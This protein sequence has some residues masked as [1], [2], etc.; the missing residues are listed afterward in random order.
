MT[1]LK[2]SKVVYKTQRPSPRLKCLLFKHLVSVRDM[3]GSVPVYEK[4]A[5]DTMNGP[6]CSRLVII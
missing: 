3:L 5:V 1:P 2:I 6:W 4:A